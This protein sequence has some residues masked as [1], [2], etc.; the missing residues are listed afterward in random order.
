MLEEL[1][2]SEERRLKCNAHILLAIDNALNKTFSAVEM[3]IGIEKLISTDAAHVFSSSKDSI[4][5]LGL[6]AL[7]KLLSPSHESISLYTQYQG[8]LKI[9]AGG[10]DVKAE[11]AKCLLQKGFKR[12][13]ANRVGR[14]GSLSDTFVLHK[15]LLHEFFDEC[16]DEHANKLH[17]ACFAYLNSQCFFKCC[18]V[19][20]CFNTILTVPFKEVLGIDE[21]KCSEQKLH[22]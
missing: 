15:P 22:T 8:W 1:G 16:I 14:C 20:T 9:V 13:Q 21:G 11:E 5:I 2:V 7:A 10:S 19:A 6:I 17:L 3:N 18:Q 12:F 4:W